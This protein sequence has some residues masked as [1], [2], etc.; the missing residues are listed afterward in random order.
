ADAYFDTLVVPTDIPG[1]EG[2]A[3][4]DVY[5]NEIVGNECTVDAQ[6]R[7]TPELTTGDVDAGTTTAFDVTG[8]VRHTDYTATTEFGS[9]PFTADEAGRAAVAIAVPADATA[10]AYE[11]S[12][13]PADPE[14][15]DPTVRADGTFQVLVPEPAPTDTG[16]PTPTDTGGPDGTGDTGGTDGAGSATPPG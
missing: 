3:T 13:V 11:V 2:V 5:S 7:P 14:A 15:N 6:F 1:A 16:E 12:V 8:L 10:G 9:V 4:K